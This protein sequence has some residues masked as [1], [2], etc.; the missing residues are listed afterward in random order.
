VEA[1]GK[2]TILRAGVAVALVFAVLVSDAAATT[3]SNA[4]VRGLVLFAGDSNETL[5]AAQINW[6]LTGVPVLGD[7]PHKDNGYVVMMASR[8]GAAVRT[9]DCLPQVSSCPTND[10]W[11][12]RFQAIFAKA[13]P[14]AIVTDLGVN[15]TIEAGTQTTPGYAFFGRKIDWFMRL[16][17]KTTTV[18]WSNLPC[19]IEPA[20][21]QTGCAQVNWTLALARAT[22]PNLVLLDWNSIANLHP[23]WIDPVSGVHLTDDGNAAWAAMVVAALDARFPPL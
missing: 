5:A 8:S 9:P 14:D 13:K 20:S 17:P 10:Y 23:E 1:L 15:D 19:R 2:R 12:L 11:K 22:W 18:F 16:V 6:A 3:T 7:T 21:R 4:G